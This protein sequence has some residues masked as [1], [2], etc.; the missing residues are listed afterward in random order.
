MKK[1]RL[2]VDELQVQ[3]FTVDEEPRNRGTVRAH[4]DVRTDAVECPTANPAWDTCWDSCHGSC[5]C[6]PSADCSVD[7]WYTLDWDCQSDLDCMY[8][9]PGGSEC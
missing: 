4:D 8:T 3:S 5:Q 6:N 7:C 1:M 2:V 9:Y